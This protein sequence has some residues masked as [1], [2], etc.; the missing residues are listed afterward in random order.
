MIQHVVCAIR[1]G[2]ESQET[3]TS[4]I[5]LALKD[6]TTLTFFHVVDFGCI[7][8]GDIAR[9]SAAYREYMEEVESMMRA[10]CQQAQQR[11]V[12]KVDY[13]VREGETRQELRQLA[14]ETDAEVLVL[15]HPRSGSGGSIFTE[16]EFH[17]FLAELDFA[18]E[19]HTVQTG[20]PPDE[21]T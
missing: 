21:A 13:V 17:R 18:G 11:G 6:E 14:A 5:D 1:G 16:D 10:F 4:A 19:L 3:V 7:D 8:C 12:S 20:V 9:S 15:G 2:S